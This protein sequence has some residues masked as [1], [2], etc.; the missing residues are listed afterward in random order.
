MTSLGQLLPA[1]LLAA[2][3]ALGQSGVGSIA[4]ASAAPMEWDIERYDD[5]MKIGSL[6][7][8]SEKIAWTRKCCL[9]SG[10]VWN[11]SLG[12][13]Q[14]PPANAPATRWA[15]RIPVGVFAQDLTAA[16]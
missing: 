6:D 3:A 8:P 16:P 12:K 11:D 14:S 1:A 5:C 9:D 2:T 13:C 7:D 15:G 4:T 10:G